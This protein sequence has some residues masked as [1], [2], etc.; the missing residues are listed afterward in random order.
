MSESNSKTS[1]FVWV[2]IGCGGL[3]VLLL[4]LVLFGGLFLGVSTTTAIPSPTTIPAPEAPPPP[5]PP[6]TNPNGR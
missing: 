3:V 6:P 4:L 1:P 2:A 5:A